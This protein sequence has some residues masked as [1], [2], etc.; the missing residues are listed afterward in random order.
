MAAAY[1]GG[2]ISSHSLSWNLNTN[3]KVHAH[4]SH[5]V[6]LIVWTI[7]TAVLAVTGSI[8]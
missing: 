2:G 1:G 3:P 4:I 7:S 6:L 8:L 5:T